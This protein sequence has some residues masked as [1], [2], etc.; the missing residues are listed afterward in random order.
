LQSH[1]MRKI[2]TSQQC[3]S[4]SFTKHN[5]Q[6]YPKLPVRLAACCVFRHC[7]VISVESFPELTL[8]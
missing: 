2:E 4:F 8:L 1:L 5:V 6:W 7:S 3:C